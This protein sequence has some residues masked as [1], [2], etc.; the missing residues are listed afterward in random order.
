MTILW[1]IIKEPLSVG[2]LRHKAGVENGGSLGHRRIA[3][4]MDK[5]FQWK[6][7]NA[8]LCLSSLQTPMLLHNNI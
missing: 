6:F 8:S 5:D 1:I 4:K 2:V 3:I 7:Q